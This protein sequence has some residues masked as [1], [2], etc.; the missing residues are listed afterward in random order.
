M[1]KKHKKVS[2]IL[3]YIEHLLIW[4]SV[5]TWFVLISDCASLV[6]IPFGITSFA[7]SLKYIFGKKLS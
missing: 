7:V 1:S 5:I 2:R 3:N 6:G 4:G